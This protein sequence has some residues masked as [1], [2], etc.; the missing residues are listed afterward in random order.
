MKWCEYLITCLK[1]TK[2]EWTSNEPFNGPLMFLAKDVFANYLLSKDHPNTLKIYHLTSILL[3]L[4]W[5]TTKNRVDCGVFSMRHMETYMGGGVKKWMTGLHQE[6]EAQ[7]KQL[8]QLHFKYLCKILL[9]NVNILKDDV[10]VQAREHDSLGRT[11]QTVATATP[12]AVRYLVVLFM[13]DE[14]KTDVQQL[15][16]IANIIKTLRCSTKLKVDFLN[17]ICNLLFI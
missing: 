7:S 10:V 12:N 13:V 11:Q 3:D 5:K 16:I 2:K 9:S 6:S 14:D 1:R 17:P 15:Q 8:N 4:P